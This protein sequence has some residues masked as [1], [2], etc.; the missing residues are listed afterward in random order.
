[1]DLRKK[2][3]A[4][5]FET[6]AFGRKKRINI[7]GEHLMYDESGEPYLEKIAVETFKVTKK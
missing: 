2:I 5:K 6:D 3:G 7:F 4:K 1:M